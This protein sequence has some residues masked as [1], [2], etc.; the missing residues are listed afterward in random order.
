MYQNRIV[1]EAKQ[2]SEIYMIFHKKFEFDKTF[3]F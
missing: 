3:D 1:D 2:E